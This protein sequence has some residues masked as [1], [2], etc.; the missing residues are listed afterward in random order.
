MFFA[1]LKITA[2][3]YFWQAADSLVQMLGGRGY[4]D[5]NIASQLLR[6]ARVARILEGPTEA[7]QMFLGARVTKDSSEFFQFL[8]SLDRQRDVENTRQAGLSE[9]IKQAVAA[10]DQS[11]KANHR[12]LSAV[13]DIAAHAILLAC[14]RADGR[15]RKYM[16]S[17]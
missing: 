15:S 4:I 5:T 2:P 17:G 1:A 3:E 16:S 14:L 8:D 10:H 12:Y 7:L 6:D 13:G 11:S 9:A